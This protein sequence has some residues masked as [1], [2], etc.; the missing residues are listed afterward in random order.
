MIWA[1]C[2]VAPFVLLVSA[3]AHAMTYLGVDPQDTVPGVMLLQVV[4]FV[5][6]GAALYYTGRAGGGLRR[7]AQDRVLAAAPLGLRVLTGLIIAYV[8]VNFLLLLSG[9]R[10]GC[11]SGPATART[12]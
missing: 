6:F 7:D 5:P 1:W 9:W 2:G 10:P 11:R 12:P 3:A 8:G 4:M